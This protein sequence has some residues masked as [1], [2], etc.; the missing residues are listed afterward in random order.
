MTSSLLDSS[1]PVVSYKKSETTRSA[2]EATRLFIRMH[3]FSRRDKKKNI[4]GLF[5]KKQKNKFIWAKRVNII[6]YFIVFHVIEV[7]KSVRYI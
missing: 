7:N 6:Y 4:L 3:H 5:Q 1:S 2:R